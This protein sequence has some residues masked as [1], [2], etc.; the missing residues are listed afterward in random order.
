MSPDWKFEIIEC[1]DL[2]QDDDGVTFQSEAECR[3]NRYVELADSVTGDEGSAGVAAIVPSLKAKGDYGAYQ[4]AH[5]ALLRF[6]GEDIGAGV[7]QAVSDLLVIPKDN[8]GNILL[9]LVHAG[10][11]ALNSFSEVLG[12]ADPGIRRRFRQLIEFHESAEWLSGAT[13]R[14]VLMIPRV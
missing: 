5:A 4:S 2:V 3:W 9:I 7:V 13:H 1:G 6:P 14:N 11:V 10:V 8:S 12:V